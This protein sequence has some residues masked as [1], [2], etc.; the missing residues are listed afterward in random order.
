MMRGV[1]VIGLEIVVIY[2]IKRAVTVL[3]GCKTAEDRVLVVVRKQ[4]ARRVSTR[5]GA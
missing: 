5:F 1:R 2:G 4:N 3:H